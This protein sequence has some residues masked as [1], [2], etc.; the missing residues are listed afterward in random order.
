MAGMSA[1]AQLAG[2]RPTDDMFDIGYDWRELAGSVRKFL[3]ECLSS[4]NERTWCYLYWLEPS[5]FRFAMKLALGMAVATMTC[6]L[7]ERRWQTKTYLELPYEDETWRKYEVVLFEA[8][9]RHIVKYAKTRKGGRI[10]TR[11]S[12]QA[13]PGMKK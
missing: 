7:P 8:L 10:P 9:A 2:L 4:F 5:D 12:S 13:L 1:V 3:T 11:I 6:S